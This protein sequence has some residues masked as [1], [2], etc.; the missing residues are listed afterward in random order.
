MLWIFDVVVFAYHFLG[1]FCFPSLHRD[2]SASPS[3]NLEININYV[4]VGRM[5]GLKVVPIQMK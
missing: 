5:L 3:D 4:N 2:V 1:G